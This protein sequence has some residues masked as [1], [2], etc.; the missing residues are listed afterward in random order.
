MNPSVDQATRFFAMFAQANVGVWPMQVVWYV[1]ALGAIGLAI[2]PIRHS[3][4][5][6]S[7][8]LAAYYVWLGIAFFAI[9]YS[10]IDDGARVAG[11]LFV[12][13]GLLFLVAGVVRQNLRFQ[14]RW[15]ALGALGGGIMLYALVAYPVVGVLTG[16]VF[17]AA[18]VFGLAPCPSTTFTAGLLLWTRPR[19]PLYVLLVPQIWLMA[20]TPAAALALGVAGDVARPFV[21]VLTTGLLVWRDYAGVR[22]RLFGAVLLALAVVLLGHVEPLIIGAALFL[23]VTFTPLFE[24]VTRWLHAGA[25]A[26]AS[27]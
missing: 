5:L 22:E 21:G 15:D 26:G 18:P 11:A 7:V 10:A 1:A 9:Y 6:I 19:L 8:F 13:G 23:L 24:P 4:R 2:N 16:H 12:V 17:P 27:P 3:S 25:R 20:Q 14:A